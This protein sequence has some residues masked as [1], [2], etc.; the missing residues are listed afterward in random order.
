M[1]ELIEWTDENL[2]TC[3]AL[4][5]YGTIKRAAQ[6]LNSLVTK[7]DIHTNERG[8]KQSY[9]PARFDLLPAEAVAQM[10]IVLGEGARKY[11]EENWRDI[12]VTDHVN[13]ALQHLFSWLANGEL[14]DLTHALV[15]I[16][17]AADLTVINYS[18]KEV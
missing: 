15:R 18:G 17:F 3:E 1:K 11:G 13:H 14:E 8:G 12:P 9:T 10:A 7:E 4:I 2:G 16:S 6:T 5:S